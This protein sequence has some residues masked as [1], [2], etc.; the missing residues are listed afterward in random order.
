MQSNLIT[1][2]R[3][4]HFGQPLRLFPERNCRV[5]GRRKPNDESSLRRRRVQVCSSTS[6]DD[7]TITSSNHEGRINRIGETRCST[8]TSIAA[9]VPRGAER[10]L[11]A[12]YG[13]PAL[14]H[15]REPIGEIVFIILSAPTRGTERQ[16]PFRRLGTSFRKWAEVRDSTPKQIQQTIGKAGLSRTKALQIRR[17]LQQLTRDIGRL[18]GTPLRRLENSCLKKP[19]RHGPTCHHA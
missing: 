5:A 4:L 15:T 8:R 17:A 16:A 9:E 3:R 6:E 19:R 2:T 18:P 14:G 13:T 7:L 12:R 1:S 10:L 11:S